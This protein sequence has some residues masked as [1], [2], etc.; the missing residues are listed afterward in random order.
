MGFR[1]LL[2]YI[3]VANQRGMAKSEVIDSDTTVRLNCINILYYINDTDFGLC[4]QSAEK[5]MIYFGYLL[6]VYFCLQVSLH[7]HM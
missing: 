7:R 2:M 3:R 4:A 1:H 5:Q 6:L